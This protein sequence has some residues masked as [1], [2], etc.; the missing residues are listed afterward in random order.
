MDFFK[1]LRRRKAGVHP[2]QIIFERENTE[3]TYITWEDKMKPRIDLDDGITQ[4]EHLALASRWDEM[5]SLA[6]EIIW[7]NYLNPKS[8][9]LMSEV[10]SF[11]DIRFLT[12]DY[13]VGDVS[14]GYIYR[15]KKYQAYHIKEGRL[16]H[17]HHNG[18]EWVSEWLPLDSPEI[19]RYYQ[20]LLSLRLTGDE[21]GE[22]DDYMGLGL[23]AEFLKLDDPLEFE[24][25]S[26]DVI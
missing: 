12:G 8:D 22:E 13:Y 7:R 9:D 5:L 10:N 6:E 24:I 16:R 11:P 17:K 3:N 4:E 2:H 23:G 1:H 14:Y 26:H 18:K 20:I 21:G 15:D 25:L 19:T